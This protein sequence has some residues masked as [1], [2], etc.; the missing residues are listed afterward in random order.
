MLLLR[1]A[2]A[3]R[4]K[5]LVDAVRQVA[6]D[7]R[8]ALELLVQDHACLPVHRPPQ[9]MGQFEGILRTNTATSK[10][11]WIQEQNVEEKLDDLPCTQP[12]LARRCAELLAELRNRR[13]ELRLM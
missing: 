7:A 11:F 8:G 1:F 2:G 10:N 9:V 12:C 6:Q 5:Q 3:V 4:L 13:R